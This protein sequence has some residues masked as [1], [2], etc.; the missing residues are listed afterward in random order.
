M[1]SALE[2][3]LR[4]FQLECYWI[5]TAFR[6]ASSSRIKERE[7]QLAAEMAVMRIHDAWARYCR[8]QILLS[9]VGNHQ[10]L[11]GLRITPALGVTSRNAALLTLLRGN[12]NNW[13]PRWAD[14]TKAISAATALAISNLPT[15]SSAL[16]AVDNPAEDVRRVRNY[17]AHRTSRTASEA[18]ATGLFPSG[19]PNVWDLGLPTHAGVNTIEHWSGRFELVAVAMI[20]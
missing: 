10:S 3:T 19:R 9:A 20:Q 12:L 17:F 11:S 13:E 7:M 14:A 6:K 15:I 2:K 16:A 8:E 4:A 18:I 1:P 5:S